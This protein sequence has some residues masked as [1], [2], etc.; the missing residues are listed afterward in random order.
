MG[1]MPTK[2]CALIWESLEKT[3]WKVKLRQQRSEEVLFGLTD[4]TFQVESMFHHLYPNCSWCCFSGFQNLYLNFHIFAIFTGHFVS[5]QFN[6]LALFEDNSFIHLSC[7]G[8]AGYGAGYG[9][10]G[11]SKV[12]SPVSTVVNHGYASPAYGLYSFCF[13]FQS[14]KCIYS[15]V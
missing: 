15:L 3:L 10:Y 7:L 5:D 6:F 4:F 2:L 13:S 11:V 12:V 14:Y 9:G 8:Y 1:I